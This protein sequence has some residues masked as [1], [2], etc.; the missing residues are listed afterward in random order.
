MCGRFLWASSGEAIADYLQVPALKTLRPRY[1]VAPS[2]PVPSVAADKAGVRQLGWL[3]WGLVPRWSSDP[4]KAPINARAETAA[5]KPF[6]TD[7]LRLR[8][9]LIP[10]D[11]FYEWAQLPGRRKQPYCFRVRDDKPFAFAGLWDV[12]KDPAGRPLPTFCILTTAA[13]E[14]VRPV[15]GRMPVIVPERHLDLWLARGVQEPA[16]LAPVLRPY[17]ADLMHALPV[18]PTVNDPRND[19]PECLAASV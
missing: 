14:L 12:W 8:R 13:N 11:G 4:K 3:R 2:Q 9:C 19:G 16:D 18:G 17:P 15:H 10:A 1:N 5:D 6:F 7:S